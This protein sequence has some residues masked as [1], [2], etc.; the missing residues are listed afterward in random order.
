MLLRSYKIGLGVIALSAISF[1]AVPVNAR[2]QDAGTDTTDN[3]TVSQ[4][5]NKKV[6]LTV[7]SADLFYA[8]KLLFA[9]INAQYV[10]D[11]SLRGQLV[12]VTL[13]DQPFRIALETLLKSANL[14]LTYTF[15]NNIYSIIPKIEDQPQI[16]RAEQPDNSVPQASGPPVKIY[17]GSDLPFLSALNI[18]E[19]L[20]GRQ[21]KAMAGMLQYSSGGM[22]GGGGFGGGQGGRGGSGGIGGSSGGGFGGGLGGS[23]GGGGFGGGGGGFGGGGGGFG[24]G[25]GGGRGY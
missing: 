19:L 20:G 9:Q 1:V 24:G 14:P 10:L 17:K 16:D 21:I 5:P 11:S 3:S 8:L 13:K 25:I 7:E 12:T 2:A 18:V 15:E 6:S 22:G 4:I 23:S